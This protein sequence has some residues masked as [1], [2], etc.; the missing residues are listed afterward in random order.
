MD[1]KNS[2][3]LDAELSKLSPFELKGRIIA[4]A[5][6]KVKNAAYTLLNAGRG[7]PN[8]LAIESRKAFFAIGMFAVEESERDFCLP[9]GIS[10]VPQKAGISVRFE[11]W[12]RKHAGEP[13]VDFLKGAYE[14]A[15]TELSADADSLIEEW[16]G[17]IMGHNYPTPPR[18]LN[19]T[20][21]IVQKYL[22]WALCAGNPPKDT[23][24]DLF[25]V[26]GST[27]GMCY[28]FDVLKHNFLLSAGDSVA[29]MVPVFTPYIEIPELSEFQYDVFNVKADV[30]TPDG[31]HTWQYDPAD[32]AK[33]KDHKYKM[34]FV[35]NPSNPP[36]YAIDRATVEALQEVVK[37][38]PDLMILTDDVYGT[39][40]RGYR[41]LIADL[42]FNAMSCY[43]FSKYF[44]ATGW[45]IAVTALSQNNVFD[46]LISE[47]PD[48]KK[49]ALNLR[50]QSLTLD[51]PGLKFI[52][53]MVAESRLIAL[54]HTAGLSTPQ[55]IQMS[56]MALG[57]LMDKQG[58]YHERM[59][60]LIHDRYDAMWSNF[61]FKMPDDP[62]RADY[63]SEIDLMVW[64]RKL[65][66]KEFA[67]YINK[68]YNPLSAVFRLASE[69]GAVVL[70]GDGFDGPRWSIRVS[71]ANLNE[72]D[73]VKIGKYIREILEQYAAEWKS[74]TSAK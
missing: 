1:T 42:P 26:E 65:Y 57:S 63:Y 33:L 46:K 30:M 36:S 25:A 18:I 74:A 38:N 21:R 56:F 6:E 7:N 16:A 23:T 68:N 71:L 51:V 70:N 22:D 60:K 29:L 43:S 44:G 3:T 47:L 31:L 35:T 49:A 27:A 67:D 37:E 12:M 15:L 45:R 10:G 34:L 28:C 64:A 8:W 58:A 39:F 48:D 2:A 66:G 73:Y 59:L 53:R 72:S 61:G 17:G 24:F 5:D 40:V 11:D 62:L 50:Y 13:G 14:Y 32:I 69:T 4:A 19:Y 54:N 55:Q 41:S 52:D 20:E 9:E